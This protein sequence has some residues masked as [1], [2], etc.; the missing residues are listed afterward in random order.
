M[1]SLSGVC[2]TFTGGT[3]VFAVTGATGI[4]PTQTY[5]P[6]TVPGTCT[7]TA[8]E[9]NSGV[10]NT[11]AIIQSPVVYT[12]AVAATPL[13]LTGNGI[14]TSTITATVTNT[15]GVPAGGDTVHFT[16]VGHPALTA[17][18]TLSAGGV[19]ITN[20]AGVATLT[21]TTSVVPGFCTI[22][23]VEVITGQ[24]GSTTIDQTSV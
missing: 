24:G 22:S 5:T 3:T 10:S 20:P 6:T 13:T 4:T 2:G 21:Y 16:T 14:T 12:I 11:T 9:A 17:C 19:A 15:L 23:G 18:G 7:V 1:F 8:T